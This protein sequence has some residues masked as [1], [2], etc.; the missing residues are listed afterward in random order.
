M[1]KFT[2]GKQARTTLSVSCSMQ[3]KSWASRSSNQ[4]HDKGPVNR[5]LRHRA[6][7]LYFFSLTAVPIEYV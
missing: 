1:T 6:F 2:D 4:R 5:D 7:S 3:P